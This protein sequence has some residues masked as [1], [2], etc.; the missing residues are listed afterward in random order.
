M[1][2]PGF[3]HEGNTPNRVCVI[4]LDS[5]GERQSVLAESSEGQGQLLARLG[6]GHQIAGE[7]QILRLGLQDFHVS[8]LGHFDKVFLLL[9]RLLLFVVRHTED[10]QPGLLRFVPLGED[11]ESTLIQNRNEKSKFI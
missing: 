2:Y 11:D 3:S 1:S 6:D 4:I 8:A 10:P 7:F 5:D 9:Q